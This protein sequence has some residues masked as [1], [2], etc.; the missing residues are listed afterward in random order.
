MARQDGIEDRITL[1]VGELQKYYMAEMTN[2]GYLPFKGHF[3]VEYGQKFAR[4][5]RDDSQRCV[6]C[7]VDLSNGDILKADGWKKPAKGKRGSIWN[8]G[9]DVGNNK[10]CDLNGGGL[11][12]R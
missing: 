11:Y 5:V 1:F 9:C 6:Y 10:P 8:E 7:F 12:K 4:I 2:R 3:E